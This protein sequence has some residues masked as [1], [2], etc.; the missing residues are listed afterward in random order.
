MKRSFFLLLFAVFGAVL[1]CVFA[2]A[3]DA[4]SPDD[5]G[6]ESAT[7]E[8]GAATD[9]A[10]A[11]NE[12]IESEEELVEGETGEGMEDAGEEA[13]SEA[14]ESEEE[15]V[16]QVAHAAAGE[17][18]FDPSKAR[19]PT[20]IILEDLPRDAG[21]SVAL[22]WD[23]APFD[24]K[25]REAAVEAG[26][27]ATHYILQ[28]NG[29]KVIEFDDV[30]KNAK[31]M[32]A[33]PQYW[34]F[35]DELASRR[36]LQIE[37]EGF[38]P[39]TE[40]RLQIGIVPPYL[41]SEYAEAKEK[42]STIKKLSMDLAIAIHSRTLESMRRNRAAKIEKFDQEIA[43]LRAEIAGLGYTEQEAKAEWDAVR[44]KIFYFPQ[45]Y[46]AI[47][48]TGWFNPAK[49]NNMIFA[50]LFG[51]LVL[52]FIARAR[53]DRDGARYRTDSPRG[54]RTFPPASTS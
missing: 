30:S 10:A 5:A 17:S 19:I 28:V 31:P 15:P 14:M 9:E 35:G 33:S 25:S 2:A 13:D 16:E 7:S 12:A 53:R 51:A 38:K 3:Q 11:E 50:I 45:E 22:S 34:G 24:F 54:R 4:S 32:S 18:S 1:L 6:G 29:S 39:G 37:D 41:E 8:E 36:W 21:K 46:S 43:E 44:A 48:R 49:I 23:V 47:T 20:N 42:H 40:V 52:W 26:E 27:E